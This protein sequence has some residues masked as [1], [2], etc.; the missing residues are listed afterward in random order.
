MK[1]LDETT[2]TTVEDVRTKRYQRIRKV[3]CPPHRIPIPLTRELVQD[4]ACQLSD[5]ELSADPALECGLP[6]NNN[7]VPDISTRDYQI[8]MASQQ[9]LLQVTS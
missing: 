7:S 1:R 3:V 2:S 8:A 5:R 6:L 4:V 9:S